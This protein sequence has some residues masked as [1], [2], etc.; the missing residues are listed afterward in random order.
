[1]SNKQKSNQ[2]LA[3]ILATIFFS[4][5]LISGAIAVAL[6]MTGQGMVDEKTSSSEESSLDEEPSEEDSSSALESIDENGQE[7]TPPPNIQLPEELRA[8]FIV[9]G[10]DI[11]AGELTD[12]AV[13]AEVDKAIASAVTLTANAVVIETMYQD[14]AIYR[15]G[16][17][18]GVIGGFD[19]LEY[20][21]Q[22]ANENGLLAYAT[23]NVLSENRSG[24][25]T[26]YS[27]VDNATIDSISAQ[28]TEFAEKYKLAGIYLQNYEVAGGNGFAAYQQSGSGMG[29][30]NYTRAMATSAFRAAS[31]AI[32]ESSPSTQVGLYTSAVWANKTANEA[33]SETAA[34]HQTLIDG[35]ADTKA[36]VESDL[37]DFVAVKANGYIS[38][39]AI[40]FLTVT[41]WWGGL[42]SA[43][44]IPM[45][46]VHAATNVEAGGW[47]G[48]ELA[49]QYLKVKDVSGYKG[50]VFDSLR[51]LATDQKGSA[52]KLIGAMKNEID[53]DYLLTKLVL[54]Q[55]AKT[56]STTADQTYTLIGASDREQPLTMNG[57]D[58]K[59]DDNGYFNIDV[60]LQE[61]DNVYV[62]KHKDQTL[63]Y[64]INRKVDVLKDISPMGKTTVEGGMKVNVF[65]N[66]YPDAKVTAKLGGQSVTLARVEAG[67]DVEDDEQNSSYVRYYGT[68]QTSKTDV[69]KNLGQ[70]VVTATSNGVS[71]TIEGAS[72]TITPKISI[73]D[74]QLVQVKSLAAETFP[75]DTLNDLSNGNFFPICEGAMDYTASDELEYSDGSK[76]YY[77]YLLQSGRRVYSQDISVIKD[78]IDLN[79]NKVTGAAISSSGG[80][81]KVVFKTQKQ[82][83]YTLKQDG[84]NIAIKFHYTTSVPD[85][86]TVS[87]NPMFTSMSWAGT[88]ATLKMKNASA[89]IGYTA[90]YEG[91]DLVFKFKNSP[92]GLSGARIF[93]D[94]G[95]SSDSVGAVGNHGDMSEYAINLKISNYLKDIL[96]DNGATVKMLNNGS[97]VELEDRMAQVEA[98]NPHVS[99]SV[100][101]NSA[102]GN[103]SAG[104]SEAYYF[105]QYSAGLAKSV[106]ANM[107][108]ALGITNRG[109][110]SGRFY[111]TRT[112]V[113]ASTL[114]ETAFI[115]NPD[116]YDM[117][118]RSSYQKSVAAGIANGI[119]SYLGNA[120]GGAGGEVDWDDDTDGDDEDYDDEES[121]DDNNDNN[122]LYDVAITNA[123]STMKTGSSIILEAEADAD[124]TS[125]VKYTWRVNDTNYATISSAG[126]L[127]ARKKGEVKVTVTAKLGSET[128]T[129]SVVIKISDTAVTPTGLKLDREFVE[130]GRGKSVTLKATLQP[131]GA[132]GTVKWTYEGDDGITVSSDG[133]VKVASNISDNVYGEVTASIEGGEY[134]ASC[135]VDGLVDSSSG[136]STGSSS[137]S[138]IELNESTL[139]LYEG[140]EGDFLEVT[141]SPDSAEQ[142]VKWKSSNP[143]CVD[144]D[145]DGYLYA[146]K[147]GKATITVTTKNGK[148][149]A[150]CRVTVDP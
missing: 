65:A 43:N 2:K 101:T 20:A 9:P 106:S 31:D 62:F 93:I 24:D 36:W 107:S 119:N 60:E 7:E 123:P 124:D 78:D 59:R 26:A 33:G 135:A 19:V 17:S 25:L 91:G 82:V 129:D 51:I 32:R 86:G 115:S 57:E 98:F 132:A 4:I 16:D 104:G 128:A 34:P 56:S 125:D 105:Y 74:G 148:K 127:V 50:S 88:T 11:M 10:S 76:T 143:D 64:T 72:V 3:I 68:F 75:D 15:T 63:T 35:N 49:E 144:V 141:I 27:A 73:A 81:T 120:K 77:Y 109:A 136:G 70:I 69:D 8:V 6:G 113:G 126:K 108:N 23:Y 116:E 131:S 45:Y 22:K 146:L 117:M 54:T 28:T 13:K 94:P 147:E 61:G 38:D 110:K 145:P 47:D 80:T 134:T 130:I 52:T 58:V 1:M 30:Q 67:E 21:V 142:E 55:P 99:V 118:I 122:T 87:S 92:G 71:K 121:S 112:S 149:S 48:D 85:K 5:T 29:Y 66:A 18:L 41:S 39:K 53:L 100:H 42:A 84:S 89:F 79:K 44:E 103:S 150:T 37:V 114:S 46:P 96:E 102:G 90:S 137:P 133:T 138:K 14:K 40:P 140:E 97:F 12:A 95:H 83:S 139:T 111:M